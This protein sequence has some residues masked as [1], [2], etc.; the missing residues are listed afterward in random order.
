MSIF[1]CL[2]YCQQTV[3][4]ICNVKLVDVTNEAEHLIIM[5]NSP[6]ENYVNCAKSSN[7]N[8]NS[9]I[10]QEHETFADYCVFA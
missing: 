3:K 5:S 6:E 1:T 2:E 4:T 9:D 10:E 8:L 7:E